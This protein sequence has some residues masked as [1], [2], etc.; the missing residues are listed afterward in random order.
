VQGYL[1]GVAQKYELYRYIRFN[2][3]V[4]SADWDDKEKKWK[5]TVKV[6]GS[7]DAEFGES[8]T[9][10]SDFLVSAVG[11]LNVPRYPDIPGLKDFKGTT[12]HSAR[13]D[14]SY[15]LEGKRIAVIGNGCTAA[16]IIP[17]IVKVASKLTV[18]QRTPNWIIPRGDAPV[19]SLK[20]AIFKYVPPVR[21]R[22]RADMMDFRESFY[23]AVFDA[24]SPM[25]N[26]L[27]DMGRG[28]IKAQLP[29]KPELWE[30]LTP[31]YPIGCKRVIITDDYFPVFD[32]EF[33]SLE[34]RPITQITERG[35]EIEGEESEYD[36]IILATGFRT[37]E[38]MHPIKITGS[39]RR[40]IS[41][42]WAKGGR[43]LYGM[44][45]ESLPNFGMLYGPNTNLGHN[46]IILMIEAQS[47]YICALAAEVIQ[48]RQAGKSLTIAPRKERLEEF[49]EEIQ[50]KLRE[51]SFAHPSCKSWY[52]NEE[53]VITNNWSG[54]VV[55]YQK[56][57]ERVRWTDYDLA[58]SGAKRIPE[59]SSKI[60]RVVEETSVS[61]TTLA[62]GAGSLLAVGAGLAL[63]YSG[64]LR[65][66]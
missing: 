57:L 42:I 31:S 28:M 46:S 11:Q 53:G 29:D 30:K 9:L 2:T 12:M 3:S 52:K 17:E 55:E 60:P 40:S 39:A 5:T 43:A 35:I 25:A 64:R 20:R 65:V 16:Q 54:T 49:N 45:V 21:R 4:E 66:R 62:L 58:G 7:K 10:T 18:H 56:M 33:V 14:W 38:F 37:V 61:Y 34:T 51:S 32:Q 13:W 59:T 50:K 41:D 63:R 19:S 15:Q 8:Y 48:A 1:V 47:K 36:L 44:T 26:M 23:S 22:Y 6:I 27:M 24:E